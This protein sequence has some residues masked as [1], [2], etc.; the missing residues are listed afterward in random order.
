[1]QIIDISV[2]I[3]TGM[4]VYEGDPPVLVERVA[5]LAAGDLATVSRIEMGV[6]TGT[7]VDAPAHVLDGAP[8]ADALPLDALVGEA[9]VVD[10]EG[11]EGDLD[12]A[13]IAGLRIPVSAERVLFRTR[14]SRLWERERFERGYIGLT[15]DGAQAL[16]DAGVRLVGIEYLSVAASADA[17]PAHLVLLSAG[18]VILEGLDLRAAPAGSYRLVCLPLRIEGADGAPARA[19]LIRG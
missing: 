1:V 11:L 5:D 8:G 7:H 9:E 17:L 3:R 12:A 6:H 18:V 15:G 2:P 10:A 13:A 16:V 19:V 4:V 14:N